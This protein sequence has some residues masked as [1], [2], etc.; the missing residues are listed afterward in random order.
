MVQS[1]IEFCRI[2]WDIQSAARKHIVNVM[3]AGATPIL[4]NDTTKQSLQSLEQQFPHAQP[5]QAYAHDR[6]QPTIEHSLK[7]FVDNDNNDGGDDNKITL[8]RCRIILIAVAKHPGE[9]AFE[10]HNNP[11]DPVRDLRAIVYQAVAN[12][13][14]SLDHVQV[15]VLRLLPYGEST[16]R[17]SNIL[18]KQV[19][20]QISMSIYNI[21]NGQHDLKHAMRHLAQLYYNINVLHISNI[22][23]KSAGQA[24]S[25]HTVTLFYQ[26]NGYHLINQQE[27]LRNL[28]IHDPAYLKYREIKLVYS[29]R[30]KK[31][32]PGK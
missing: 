15:D 10:F 3:V 17:P 23:M 18:S 26:A 27:P 6:I 30:S 4:V 31:A 22:P 20:P 12:T 25:T 9:K 14:P 19:S 11:N 1:S 28:C 16:K 29:K 21:P 5:R 13:D 8:K 7:S 24:Q 2:V 32:L